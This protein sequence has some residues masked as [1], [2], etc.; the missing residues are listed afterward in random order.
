MIKAGEFREAAARADTALR[1]K[2]LRATVDQFS[3]RPFGYGAFDCCQFARAAFTSLR[4]RD[5]APSFDY[6][7]ETS[8]DEII[9]AHGT[10]EGLLRSI[11]G[12]PTDSPLRICDVALVK[13]PVVGEIVGVVGGASVIVPMKRG[14]ERVPMRT[15]TMGWAI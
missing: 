11:L 8:A 10:L 7:D 14:L 9:E 4:G 3:D 1:A 5:P 6:A 12:E 13:L 15:I 2:A